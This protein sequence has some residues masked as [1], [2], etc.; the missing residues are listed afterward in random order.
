MARI[1]GDKVAAFRS[2]FELSGNV[3]C[4]V[5]LLWVPAEEWV[6]ADFTKRA[7]LMDKIKLR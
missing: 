3:F 5:L 6:A 4:F 2:L 1:Q 7:R